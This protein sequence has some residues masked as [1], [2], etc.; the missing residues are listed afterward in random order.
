MRKTIGLLIML[1]CSELALAQADSV[2]LNQDAIYRRP[3]ITNNTRTAVGGYVEGNTNY[4]FE[5]G[6]TEGFSMEMRRFNIFLF[7]AIN[8]RI[9]FMS[10]LE[11]EHGTEEIAL[12]S[13]FLD[14]KWSPALNFRAGILLPSLGIFNANHDSPN[15]EFI[16]RPISS[17]RLLPSTL[18]EVG[19]GL[20]GAAYTKKF[21]YAYQVFLTNGLGAEITN[22]ADGRTSLQEGKRPSMFAEDNN[23][24]PMINAH[25]SIGNYKLGEVGISYYGGRY[26][27]FIL[28]DLDIDQKRSLNVWTLD[29]NINI[30]KLNVKG[31][32][33]FASIDVR[34]DL[35]PLYAESQRAGFMDLIYPV[36]SRKML[37]FPKAVL[38]LSL[39]LEEFDLNRGNFNSTQTNIG[40][41]GWRVGLG[42]GFRPVNGTILRFNYF[43]G[44]ESD[45]LDNPAVQFGGYQFGVASYF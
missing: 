45:Y 17:T 12:E 1:W 11:F 28:E 7:S 44:I 8:S 25:A 24:V 40:D 26:N 35:L 41:E 16:D 14:F 6:L 33:A 4:L 10:E 38:N 19:F 5:D 29:Y 23:G 43:R 13:A 31:E 34:P 21:V 36:L 15:W 37:R 39:R 22:N 32:Y 18:S 3:F 2:Q 30:K 9:K 20:H 27:N 42:I